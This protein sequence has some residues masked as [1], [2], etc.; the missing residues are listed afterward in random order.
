MSLKSW[1]TTQMEILLGF[2]DPTLVDHIIKLEG[3]VV[4]FFQKKFFSNFF[5]KYFLVRKSGYFLRIHKNLK[6]FSCV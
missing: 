5:V 1:V 3:R 2:S 4:E 6:K